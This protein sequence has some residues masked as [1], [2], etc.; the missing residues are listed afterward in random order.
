MDCHRAVLLR[1]ETDQPLHVLCSRCGSRAAVIALSRH[2]HAPPA[3]ISVSLIGSRSPS[4]AATMILRAIISTIAS[5]RS[6]SPSLTKAASNASPMAS[7]SSGLN[8]PLLLRYARI[9]TARALPGGLL[10]LRPVC[11]DGSPRPNITAAGPP[12]N[13]LLSKVR[14]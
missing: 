11:T 7:K 9:G 13:L 1:V 12:A 14:Q 5:L 4:I 6:C 3:P 10:R 8:D 2:P